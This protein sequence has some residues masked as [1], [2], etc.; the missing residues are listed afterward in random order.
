MLN[1]FI[2]SKHFLYVRKKCVRIRMRET[3]ILYLDKVINAI[4]GKKNSPYLIVLRAK[5]SVYVKLWIRI[6]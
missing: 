2:H 5:L 3:K 1:N 6:L 4:T